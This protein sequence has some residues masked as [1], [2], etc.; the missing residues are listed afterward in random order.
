MAPPSG[1]LNRLQSKSS[2]SHRIWLK[3]PIIFGTPRMTNPMRQ[4]P[5]SAERGR[6]LRQGF[7]AGCRSGRP[8]VSYL[9]ELEKT[10][11]IW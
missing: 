2:Q 4:C 7:A 9:Y 1:K 6:A 3:T 5:L 8:P 11:N 10:L